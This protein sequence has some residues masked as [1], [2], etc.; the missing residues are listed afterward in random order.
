MYNFY[1]RFCFILATIQFLILMGNALTDRLFVIES[2]IE[3]WLDFFRIFGTSNQSCEISL[4]FAIYAITSDQNVS[5]DLNYHW[6]ISQLEFKRKPK[7]YIVVKNAPW[8]AVP[9][10]REGLLE[11]PPNCWSLLPLFMHTYELSKLVQLCTLKRWKI[12]NTA[13]QSFLMILNEMKHMQPV[14][15]INLLNKL[16]QE[17]K[18]ALA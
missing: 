5:F 12:Q 17:K 13:L 1:L 4:I 9:A 10:T 14:N 16:Y 8:L 7:T 3:S 2:S 15:A 11:L 18:L 6:E